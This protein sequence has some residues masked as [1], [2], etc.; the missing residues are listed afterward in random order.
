MAAASAKTRSRKGKD[1]IVVPDEFVAID[2]E[3]TGRS[4]DRNEIIE[5]S[6]VRYRNG[7]A[8]E[9]Y[10]TLIKPD[11]PVNLFISMLTEQKAQGRA[12]RL[13][14]FLSSLEIYRLLG[15][16]GSQHRL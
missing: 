13:R 10:E 3:T 14:R 11:R 6:A 8:V 7:R 16:C 15:A 1:S 2:T 4:P 12:A 9:A 5:V